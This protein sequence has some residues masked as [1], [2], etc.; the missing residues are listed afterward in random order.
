MLHGT[1]ETQFLVIILF[2]KS[3]LYFQKSKQEINVNLSPAKGWCLTGN[4]RTYT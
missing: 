1:Q 3:M 2:L 4:N